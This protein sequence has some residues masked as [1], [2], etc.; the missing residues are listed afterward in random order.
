M[1]FP[2]AINRERKWLLVGG[3]GYTYRS[4]NF[5]A[6]LPY[7]LIF[8]ATPQ[9]SGLYVTAGLLGMQSLKGDPRS[10]LANP[11]STVSGAGGS[12][13]VNAINPTLMAARMQLGYQFRP[14]FTLLATLG[15][16]IY[17]Q[18]S[19]KGTTLGIGLVYMWGGKRSAAQPQQTAQSTSQ[20]NQGFITYSFEAKVTK[21]SDRLNMI[22][23]DKG[24]ADGVQAR[25]IFD[26]FSVNNGK[27]GGAIARA[28][29]IS[30]KSGEAVLQVT[31][32]FKEVW[33]EEGFIVKRPLR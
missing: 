17:G 8:Q 11:T 25:Q 21:A 31:E 27:I 1:T 10:T 32:Y 6:A 18:G 26:I 33:I 22:K 2:I 5:S 15:T 7:S 24:S 19:P 16:A 12:A 4:D 30:V 9:I 29:C 20:A 3:G 28:R 23:I 14:A 13:M